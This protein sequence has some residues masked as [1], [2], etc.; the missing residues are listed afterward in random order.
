MATARGNG[1]EIAAVPLAVGCARFCA[2]PCC[3]Q[4]VGR[5][6]TWFAPRWSRFTPRSGCRTFFAPG[7]N[8]PRDM[9]VR[10][11]DPADGEFSPTVTW[12]TYPS[13]IYV[14]PYQSAEKFPAKVMAV[15]AA[16]DLAILSVEDEAF[17]TNT[18][19]AAARREPAASKGFG[20]RVWLSN[21]RR[22]DVGDRRGSRRASNTRPITSARWDCGFRSMPRE[23]RQ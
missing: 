4:W 19:G 13:Q 6:R 7:R 17:F 22:P 9:S 2:C 8:R 5:N 15:S 14:Q 23:S 3:R 12:C 1:C 16:M 20:Q 18:A 11:C 10:L 21:R